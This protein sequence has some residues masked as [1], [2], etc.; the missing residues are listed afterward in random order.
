MLKLL[1]FVLLSFTLQFSFAAEQAC[2]KLAAK[3]DGLDENYR[4]P[5]EGK[6]IGNKKHYFYTAPDLQCKMKGVFV[7]KGDS[8]TV[9]KPYKDWLNVMY[10]AKNGEDYIGWISSKQVKILG[11][12]G[13]NP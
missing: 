10:I 1:L 9:Y 7:I 3:V 4:P 6:V 2:T 8:L 11:Q 13:N 12:Y 5:I